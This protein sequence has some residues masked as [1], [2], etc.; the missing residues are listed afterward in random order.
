MAWPHHKSWIFMNSAPRPQLMSTKA[1]HD[2]PIRSVVPGAA[3]REKARPVPR[4]NGPAP[5]DGLRG[6]KTG[7]FI[8]W[9][10]QWTLSVRELSSS[11]STRC[12]IHGK[13]KAELEL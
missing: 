7:A 9:G 1:P 13:G 6:V 2:N 12:G 8:L 4:G 10:R 3:Y 5:G 11:R